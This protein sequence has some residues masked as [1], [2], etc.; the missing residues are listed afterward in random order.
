MASGQETGQKQIAESFCSVLKRWN[1]SK[2]ILMRMMS[3]TIVAAIKEIVGFYDE[4][5]YS[6]DE[7]GY[8]QACER[9]VPYKSYFVNN[10]IPEVDEKD[11]SRSAKLEESMSKSQSETVQNSN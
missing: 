1:E 9:D 3:S 7:Q 5:P 4:D 2:S 11:S 8:H 6:M 10:S